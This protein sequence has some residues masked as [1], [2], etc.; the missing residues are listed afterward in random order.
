MIDKKDKKPERLMQIERFLSK[1]NVIIT[2]LAVM[3]LFFFFAG[4]FV[5]NSAMKIPMILKDLENPGKYINIGNILP[6]FEII[7]R[8]KG[9]YTLLLAFLTIALIIFDLYTAY[10]IKV[11]WSEEYFNI[12]QKGESRWTTNEEIKEQFDEIPDRNIPFEGRGGAIVSRIK[13][14]LYIDRSPVNNLDIGTTRSGKDEMFVYPELDVYSRAMEKTS[15][16]VNDPKLESYKASKRTLEKRGYKVYLL[17]FDD[18]LHSAGFNPLDMIVKLSS[19]GDYAN[20]ELLAQAFAFSIFNPD[21]PANTDRFWNDASTSLLVALILGHLEDCMKLDEINNNRRYVAWREKRSAYDQL[22][23]EEKIE[24]DRKYEE[25]LNK[26]Q[27]IILNPEIKYLP[28]KEE[29]RL[30][31]DNIKKINMYS[32]INTFTELARIHPDEDN[33]DMTMLD[34]YFSNRPPLNRAKLKYAAIEISGDRTKSSIFS[35]ML[36]KLT[37]FT[38]EG[39]AK[40]TAESSFNLEEIGFGEQPI[41]VFL[42]LPDYDKSKHFMATVFIRQLYFILAKKAT[43]IKSGKCS[44]HVKFKVNEFGNMPA[45]E[46]MD[47]IITVCLGRNISFDLTVQSYA[48][49][50]KLY[51]QEGASVIKENCGNH[52]YILTNSGDTAQEFSD[53]LGNETIV[54]M[55]R[56]GEKLST[57]KHFMENTQE[58]PLLNKNQLMELLPGECV[59]KRVMKREDLKRNKVK[60]TPIFNSEES[61]KCFLYRY[62]YLTETFP[63]PDTV[64]LSEVN[65]E[66]RSYINLKKRV[67]DY[68]ISILWIEQNMM[69]GLYDKSDISSLTN[70]KE[71]LDALDKVGI[72]VDKETSIMEVVDLI[73]TK[74]K[75]DDEREA[76]LS[77]IKIGS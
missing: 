12:G 68:K 19:A 7:G 71:I 13:D 45:I 21:E 39:I 54:D 27:D 24:A 50:T 32:L 49:I 33:P 64:E 44:R 8:F 70:E 63:N 31:H 73:F 3:D 29:Y 30:K 18:P 57:H 46:N 72:K 53:L 38:D 10:K 76:L 40:M 75:E 51:G 56:S 43:G 47:T 5:Y 14:K 36:S 35:V 20:A 17:N 55:Q 62:E 15:I 23:N 26:A 2:L 58:K 69:N 65:D 61:G 42:G 25:K 9:I 41:A 77:L 67:W 48:Q 22:S 28:K 59:I 16:I 1:T 4:N 34:K 11:A 37:P 66:D 52:R 6:D 74:V 60:P